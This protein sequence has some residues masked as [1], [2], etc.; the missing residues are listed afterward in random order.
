M[1]SGDMKLFFVSLDWIKGTKHVIPYVGDRPERRDRLRYLDLFG[2]RLYRL[3][4][5]LLEKKINHILSER[6]KNERMVSHGR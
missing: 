5:D 6:F 4:H 1:D 3:K 2:N